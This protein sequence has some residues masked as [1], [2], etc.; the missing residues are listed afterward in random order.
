MVVVQGEVGELVVHGEL[1]LVV[2]VTVL[3]HGCDSY[4]VWGKH[5]K[6]GGLHLCY[7][8]NDVIS[9][10]SNVSVSFRCQFY[11][12][13]FHQVFR[14]LCLRVSLWPG[15]TSS[16]CLTVSC[17]PSRPVCQTVSP[18]ARL[19]HPRPQRRLLIEQPLSTAH[20][21]LKGSYCFLHPLVNDS[22]SSLCLSVRLRSLPC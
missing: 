18:P 12:Q 7:F 3:C 14:A 5:K 4:S 8:N 15:G 21:P 22:F 20:P 1:H 13:G 16:F 11:F 6:G 2:V 19:Q 9:V 10:E 17:A